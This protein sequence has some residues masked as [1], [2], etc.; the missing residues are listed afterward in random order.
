[1][2]SKCV[3]K[4]SNLIGSIYYPTGDVAKDLALELVNNGAPRNPNKLYQ[5]R[6]SF[7]QILFLEKVK[8]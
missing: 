2:F 1:M 7:V 4:F 3:D 5:E 8:Q 6:S